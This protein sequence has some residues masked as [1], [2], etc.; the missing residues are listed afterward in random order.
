MP[1]GSVVVF[2]GTLWHRGGANRSAAPR[3]AI[4]PQYCEAWLRQ[5]EDQL[6]A[7]PRETA[8]RYPSASRSSSATAFTRRSWVMS[9][10]C[11]RAG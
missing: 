7:I 8:A 11:T 3:L 4:T 5:I 6:L 9:T 2:M 10:A 1:A